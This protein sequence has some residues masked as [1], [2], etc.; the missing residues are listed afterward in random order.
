V[1]RKKQERKNKEKEMQVSL[2]SLQQELAS[3][4][5]LPENPEK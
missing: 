1:Q 5:I 3:R 2:W 4:K